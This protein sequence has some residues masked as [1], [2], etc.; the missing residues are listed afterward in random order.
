MNA[1]IILGT[2]VFAV[3]F[4]YKLGEAKNKKVD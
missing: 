3:W 2:I 4:G 1:L